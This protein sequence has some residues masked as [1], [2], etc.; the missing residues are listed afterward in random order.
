MCIKRP[1]VEAR[2][3]AFP[4]SQEIGSEI[5]REIIAIIQNHANGDLEY[6]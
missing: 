1:L 2:E 3:I 6:Q 5:G 4:P